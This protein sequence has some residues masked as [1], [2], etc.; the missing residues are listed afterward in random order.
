MRMRRE[1]WEHW[2]RQRQRLRQWQRQRQ[3][4]G[5]R[6][7]RGV[8]MGKAREAAVALGGA[9]T[10]TQPRRSVH[11]VGTRSYPRGHSPHTDPESASVHCCRAPARPCQQ[12]PLS[13][14]HVVTL[15]Q[16]ESPVPRVPGGQSAAQKERYKKK[17]MRDRLRRES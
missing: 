5:Q 2:H 7:S 8:H 17:P 10:T 14:A 12:P 3:E 1:A 6:Q 15:R 16:P 4:A 13:T 11:P 9:R